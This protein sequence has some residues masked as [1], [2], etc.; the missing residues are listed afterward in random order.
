MRAK[1]ALEKEAMGKL[2]PIFRELNIRMDISGYEP[3][4][5]CICHQYA[6]P[7]KKFQETLNIL[8]RENFYIGIKQPQ[9]AS[10]VVERVQEV[11]HNEML[12]ALEKGHNLQEAK[13]M[14]QTRAKEAEVRFLEQ[15]KYTLLPAMKRCIVTAIEHTKNSDEAILSKYS[16]GNLKI[17]LEDENV[18]KEEWIKE[19]ILEY[20]GEEYAQYETYEARIVAYFANQLLEYIK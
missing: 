18:L 4:M 2:A 17:I 3:V 14:A 12:A 10:D 11:A 6:F 20:I 19:H 9:K 8:E 15:N 5:D 16:L 7:D 1:T 13:W